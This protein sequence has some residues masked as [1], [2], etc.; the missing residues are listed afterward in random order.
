MANETRRLPT[1]RLSAIEYLDKGFAV[2]FPYHGVVVFGVCLTSA[3]VAWSASQ[4]P[5][6]ATQSA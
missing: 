3:A 5:T 6:C 4:G 1:G 2:K